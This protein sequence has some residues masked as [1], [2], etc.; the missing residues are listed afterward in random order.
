MASVLSLVGRLSLDK[1]GFD[2][3]MTAAGRRVHEFGHTI[4][5]H[6]AAA[7]GT[8][9]IIEFT[10]K[11]V[12]AARKLGDISEKTGVS[13]EELQKL[14]FAGRAAGVGI[15]EIA[16]AFRHLSKSRLEAMENPK[17]KPGQ[18]FSALG[19]DKIN[20]QALN[21]EQ[22]MRNVAD[23]FKNLDFGAAEMAMATELLGRAGSDLLPMFKSGLKESG[24]EAKR[25]GAILDDDVVASLKRAGDEVD[26]LQMR[27]RGPLATSIG[28]VANQVKS[29]Y[30]LVDMFAGGW[31]AFI[32]GAI[33][34][35][36]LS[37]GQEQFDKH[38]NEILD[39][40]NKENPP[41][42]DFIPKGGQGGKAG[43]E[44][45]A[46]R[47]A[48]EFAFADEKKGSAK[49]A[50]VRSGA[51]A[52]PGMFLGEL[53]AGSMPAKVDKVHEILVQIREDLIRRGIA[54]TSIK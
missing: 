21:L 41:P 16:V 25:L 19:I 31:G 53:A 27:L 54:V 3:A 33:G 9:A 40:I 24:E 4:S 43:Q 2:S 48:K 45:H 23:A 29:L 28:W 52:I 11:L 12:E 35:G 20:L 8:A 30:D 44:H 36:S 50:E 26:Q 10:L 46:E 18:V 49:T 51:G 37:A 1:T 7:F 42:N 32:G 47:I 38:Y 39:K 22:T 5:H 15:D 14:E 6:L 34:G 13:V 17:S